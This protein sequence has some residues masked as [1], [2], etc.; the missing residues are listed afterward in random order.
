M[1][2]SAICATLLAA[3]ASVGCGN[4]QDAN[5]K[6]FGVAIGQFL[7]KR[8]DLCLPPSFTHDKWPVD[9]SQ[10]E[11]SMEE[12]MPS[13]PAGQMAALAAVGLASHTEVEIDQIGWIGKPTGN[14]I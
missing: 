6:N 13:G 9:L 3:M 2:K 4:K 14:K 11:L 12:T 10:I 1:K 8:G 7:D 5:D